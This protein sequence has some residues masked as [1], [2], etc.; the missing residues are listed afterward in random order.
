MTT[1]TTIQ[2]TDVISA[3]RSV[4]NTNFSNLNTD[5]AEI[6]GQVFTGNITATNLSGTNTGD[7]TTSTIKT[8]LGITTL[9][10]SNTGDQTI[11][12]ATISLTDITTN[13]VSTSKHG[14]APKA[15]NDATKFL[16]GTGAYSSPSA[17]TG[18]SGVS[19]GPASSS[20]QTITHSLG[21]AP[22]TI[23]I[24]GIGRLAGATVS[25]VYST[26]FGIYN[27]TGNRCAYII[28]TTTAGA[29]QSP[30]NSTTFAIYMDRG[31]AGDTCSGVIQNVTST[32]F[33]IVWTA[34]G[35]VTDCQF[36]WE[37]Q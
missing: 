18:T 15:P 6:S 1:I 11:S 5:K 28:G 3:S 36:I 8:K 26:S 9:S 32:T 10:G 20:T 16:D 37:A 17:P 31:T 33:D 2:S 7:E 21:R 25:S 29:S 34:S 23:R 35:N 24:Q 13:N 12:D 22:T 4:I 14:F 27:S 30:S 19:T